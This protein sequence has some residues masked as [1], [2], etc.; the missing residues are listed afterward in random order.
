MKQTIQIGDN[1]ESS[2]SNKTT[3]NLLLIYQRIK[4]REY[5]VLPFYFLTSTPPSIEKLNI[6]YQT[7]IAQLNCP[8]YVTAVM[9]KSSADV[10]AARRA[11]GAV[12]YGEPLASSLGIDGSTQYGKDVVKARRLVTIPP[13]R[14]D[15][16]T[17][18]YLC[19]QLAQ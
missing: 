19:E 5:S 6:A 17:P 9:S 4:R 2:I 10:I 15:P 11:E 18:T 12:L 14:P 13:L 16:T 8:L 7:D 1:R 3:I